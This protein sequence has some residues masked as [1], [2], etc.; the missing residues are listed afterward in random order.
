MTSFEHGQ[1]GIPPEFLIEYADLLLFA[2]TEL[3]EELLDSST[4]NNSEASAA[5]DVG[6]EG[7][8]HES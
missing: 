1:S 7:L 8:S 5:E 3:L 4:V 2:P 6:K